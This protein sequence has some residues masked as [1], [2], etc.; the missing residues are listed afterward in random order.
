MEG[1]LEATSSRLAQNNFTNGVSKVLP[2]SSS[3]SVC[4]LPLSLNW[5]LNFEICNLSTLASSSSRRTEIGLSLGRGSG[6]LARAGTNITKPRTKTSSDLCAIGSLLV[7]ENFGTFNSRVHQGIV[8]RKSNELEG[9]VDASKP[10][11]KFQFLREREEGRSR[12][13]NAKSWESLAP[14]RRLP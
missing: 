2:S 6:C 9:N 3:P 10:R 4:L 14:D 8:H 12:N 7:G 11:K 13:T 1:G 5:G